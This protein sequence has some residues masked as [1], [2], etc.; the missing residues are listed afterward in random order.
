MNPS[1]CR[2]VR[3]QIKSIF[4]P[5]PLNSLSVTML[6]TLLHPL[7]PPEPISG[8]RTWPTFVPCPAYIP[9]AY[10]IVRTTVPETRT[11]YG[12]RTCRTGPTSYPFLTLGTE[13]PSVRRTPRRVIEESRTLHV[14]GTQTRWQ[15]PT[16]SCVSRPPK[17]FGA[18]ETPCPSPAARGGGRFG[19]KVAWPACGIIII[20]P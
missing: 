5:L 20:E 18:L 3:T 9:G 15:T 2:S 10:M 6:V 16:A 11:I 13:K 17:S 7:S 4:I 12:G 19:S 1:V 8:A 14:C